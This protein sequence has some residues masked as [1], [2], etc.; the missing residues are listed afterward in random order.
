[1]N[2]Y[3]SIYIL[4]KTNYFI[5]MSKSNNYDKVYLKNYQYLIKKLIYISY[6]F[7]PDIIFVVDQLNKHNMD[8]T[9]G[10]IKAI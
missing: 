1:M 3:N 10:Y 9:I 2:D 5:K 8:P 6:G 4:M 7:K